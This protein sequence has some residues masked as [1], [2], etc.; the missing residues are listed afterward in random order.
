[1]KCRYLSG[2][3]KKHTKAPV[4][5]RFTTFRRKTTLWET[6]NQNLNP[7]PLQSSTEVVPLVVRSRS[8]GVAMTAS[9]KTFAATLSI[10]AAQL[11]HL[12]SPRQPTEWHHVT[13]KDNQSQSMGQCWETKKKKQD[14]D[15]ITNYASCHFY[16]CFAKKMSVW[17][18]FNVCLFSSFTIVFLFMQACDDC[19]C[20]CIGCTGGRTWM[21]FF[22]ILFF[23]TLTDF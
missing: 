15:Q 18:F 2:S 22:K 6:F 10:R 1:M 12:R 3:K 13:V 23:R 20:Q 4:S 7:G 11:M 16:S 8:S 14:K 9:E 19:C 21:P 5:L 17:F